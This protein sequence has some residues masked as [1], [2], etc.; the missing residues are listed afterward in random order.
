MAKTKKQ[1]VQEVIRKLNGDV[2]SITIQTQDS[3][4]NYLGNPVTIQLTDQQLSD[5]CLTSPP[6]ASLFVIRNRLIPAYK[7][8][9]DNYV[10]NTPMTIEDFK[11]DDVI[12]LLDGHIVE[13]RQELKC[14]WCHIRASLTRVRL[15]F[16]LSD[17]VYQ[18]QTHGVHYVYFCEACLKVLFN[19]ATAMINS[20]EVTV[21]E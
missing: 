19:N 6:A 5:L 1:K 2:S 20:Y 10:S 9:N 17:P 18:A 16:N 12:V 11:V 8:A 14:S 15:R 4:G 21:L 3:F 7:Y 13:H